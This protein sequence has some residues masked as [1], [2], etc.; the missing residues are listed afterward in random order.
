MSDVGRS[1]PRMPLN[2]L[3]SAASMERPSPR[4]YIPFWLVSSRDTSQTGTPRGKVRTRRSPRI[5]PSPDVASAE[6]HPMRCVFTSPLSTSPH[7]SL[8]LPAPTSLIR[9]FPGQPHP[10]CPRSCPPLPER[11][12]NWLVWFG[13]SFHLECQSLTGLV[14]WER[15]ERVHSRYRTPVGSLHRRRLKMA[16]LRGPSATYTLRS[17]MLC[18]DPR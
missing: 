11:R 13:S 18:P 4:S 10:P 3:P 5:C 17:A 14:P 8:R 2:F 9:T 6:H 16:L 7:P 1:Q 12:D 15:K